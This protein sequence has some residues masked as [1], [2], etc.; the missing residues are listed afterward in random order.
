MEAVR[1][2]HKTGNFAFWLGLL[3]ILIIPIYYLF[4]RFQAGN[5][6]AEVVVDTIVAAIYQVVVATILITN[7]RKLRS[8]TDANVK[9]AYKPIKWLIWTLVIILLLGL[10]SLL[11]SLGGGVGANG[12]GLLNLLFLVSVVRSKNA[13]RKYEVNLPQQPTVPS[14]PQ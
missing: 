5:T 3:Q 8:I 10:V 6:Q 11:L 4:F 7:G 1:Q 9:D 2:L 13:L 14:M 12:P